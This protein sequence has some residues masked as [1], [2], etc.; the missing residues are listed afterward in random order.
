[1]PWGPVTYV[2]FPITDQS[3]PAD[4]AEF[5]KLIDW[6]IEQ[7]RAGKKVHCG[8]IGGHGRT[9]IFLS[10]LINRINGRKDASAWM[11]QN[12]CNKAIESKKQVDWLETEYG[13]ERVEPRHAHVTKS[14]GH[15]TSKWDKNQSAKMNFGNSK[16]SSG[17]SSGSKPHVYDHI[18][19]RSVFGS[20]LT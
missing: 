9:G 19:N 6:T 7:M 20:N 1:V 8:C 13:I 16:P 12:Y 3:V 18:P 15:S 2:R 4:K 14:T 10:V 5:D 17:Y 11:R